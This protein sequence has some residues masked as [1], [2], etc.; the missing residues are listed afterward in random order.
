MKY[1]HISFIL[2]LF[3]LGGCSI[4][5]NTLQNISKQDCRR[6]L[7]FEERR[8]CEKRHAQ[9]YDEYNKEIYNKKSS[10]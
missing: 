9:T 3:L 1:T 7:N 6:I 4:T 8:E 2:M 10:N 5:H